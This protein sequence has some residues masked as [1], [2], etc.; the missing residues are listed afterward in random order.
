MSNN[1]GVWVYRS[2]LRKGEVRLVVSKAEDGGQALAQRHRVNERNQ[3][4]V[5]MPGDTMHGPNLA[6]ALEWLRT[7]HLQLVADGYT[8][9]DTAGMA[10]SIALLPS[11]EASAT[12]AQLIALRRATVATGRT[13]AIR[14]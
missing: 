9:A 8:L 11:R 5:L 3:G 4:Q 12:A 6:A 10:R 7:K 13:E 1:T 14:A 2:P